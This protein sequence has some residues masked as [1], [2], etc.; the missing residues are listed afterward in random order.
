MQA[1]PPQGGSGTGAAGTCDPDIVYTD[2]SGWRNPEYVSLGCDAL[3][4]LKGSTPIQAYSDYMRSF[5][6]YLA[7]SSW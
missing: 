5:R 4:M 7:T 3:P 1:T 6:D 2:R